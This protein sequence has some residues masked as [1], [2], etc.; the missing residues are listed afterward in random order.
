MFDGDYEYNQRSH[1]QWQLGWFRSVTLLVALESSFSGSF[2]RSTIYNKR[3]KLTM[4][5]AHVGPNGELIRQHSAVCR[6][7]SKCERYG[8]SCSMYKADD[9]GSVVDR[10]LI[11]LVSV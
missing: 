9:G 7:H 11:F 6:H 5:R 10:W 1:R 4:W 8:L 3:K 2:L